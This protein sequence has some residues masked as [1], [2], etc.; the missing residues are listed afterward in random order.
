MIDASLEKKYIKE[1]KKG[2][3]PDKLW[4]CIIYDGEGE[5]EQA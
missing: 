5:G 3:P 2:C 1:T 4:T